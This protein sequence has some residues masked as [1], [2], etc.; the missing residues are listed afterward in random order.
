[1][2]MMERNKIVIVMTDICQIKSTA[3]YILISL[4]LHNARTCRGLFNSDF[5][6]DFFL[7]TTEPIFV[8]LFIFFKY[9]F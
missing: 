5:G 9:T 3:G 1:M 6:F 8:W 2:E 4:L 7:N